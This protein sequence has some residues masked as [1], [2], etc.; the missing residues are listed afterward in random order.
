MQQNIY[1]CFLIS[2]CFLLGLGCAYGEETSA[3][4]AEE[5]EVVEIPLYQGMGVKLDLGNSIYEAAISAGKGMSVEAMVYAN[6]KRKY[7]P[8]VE[9]G[10][11]A[12]KRTANNDAT[13]EGKGAFMRLGCDFNIMKNKNIE[14]MFLLGVRWG[15]AV[16]QCTIGNIIISDPYW[17]ITQTLPARQMARFDCWGEVVGGVQVDVYK[18][19]IMGWNVRIKA[20]FT[21]VQEGKY[22]PAYIPG[23]GHNNNTTFSFNYYIGYKF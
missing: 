22:S 19:F 15:A 5:E 21:T 9:V 23:F 16:Q 11:G 17:D 14:N 12:L 18:G 2:V 10:Y 3:K 13:F 4:P 1:R 20:L 8:T 6:L 7:L